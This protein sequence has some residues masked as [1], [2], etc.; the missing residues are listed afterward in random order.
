MRVLQ[1]QTCLLPS[2]MILSNSSLAA[3]SLACMEGG[4]GRQRGMEGNGELKAEGNGRQRGIEG[5]GDWKAKGN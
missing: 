3:C 2:V 5:R 4:K 1:I